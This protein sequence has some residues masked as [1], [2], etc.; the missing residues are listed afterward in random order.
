MRNQQ[1]VLSVVPPMRSSQ[2][3][4][5]QRV[6]RE[7]SDTVT[8]I[9]EMLT[10]EPIVADVVRQYPIVA[11]DEQ[12]LGVSMGHPLIHR[13]AV[14]RG[15]ASA[16]PYVYAESNFVPDRL[17]DLA[18]GQWPN[19]NRRYKRAHRPHPDDPRGATWPDRRSCTLRSPTPFRRSPWTMEPRGDLGRVPISSAGRRAPRL[20]HPGV[21]LRLG[22]RCARPPSPCV[23][24]AV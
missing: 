4:D 13:I 9:L 7:S 10:G 21:V 23:I 12:A 14:L 16:R 6:L 22:P 20:R 11:G 15:G 18:Q 3:A 2:T 5:L 17:P 8:Q 24:P 1:Y 19:G